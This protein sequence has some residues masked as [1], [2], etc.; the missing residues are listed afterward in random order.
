MAHFRSSHLKG[1]AL[2]VTLCSWN[3][4]VAD[5]GQSQ[6]V[7][8]TV[9]GGNTDLADGSIALEEGRIEDG[10]RLTLEGLRYATDSRETGAAHSNLCGGYAML[11]EWALALPQCDAAIEL[12]PTNWEPLNNRAAVYAGLGRY[13]LAL[14]DLHAGLALDPKS[15]TLQKSLAVVEH[16]QKVLNERRSSYLHT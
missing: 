9:L 14:L 15:P 11:R 12:E 5:A 7:S 8:D 3:V 13:D 2:A 16:N 4:C 6:A 10:I 1:V